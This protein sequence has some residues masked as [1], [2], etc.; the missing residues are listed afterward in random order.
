MAKIFSV[1][2]NESIENYTDLIKH[3]VQVSR[4]SS[5][6]SFDL[7]SI[8]ENTRKALVVTLTDLPN[9]EIHIVDDS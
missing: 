6:F 8:D 3:N 1:F 5:L 7:D 9:T 4:G 2:Q